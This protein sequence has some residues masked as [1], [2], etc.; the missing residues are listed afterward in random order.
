MSTTRRPMTDAETNAFI[1]KINTEFTVKLSYIELAA[2]ASCAYGHLNMID[3]CRREGRP[4]P[5]YVPGEED[6][7]KLD[8]EATISAYQKIDKFKLP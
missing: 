2:L 8:Y 5:G 6:I 4:V 1:D 3:E 7:Q